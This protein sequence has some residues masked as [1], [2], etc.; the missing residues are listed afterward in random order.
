[1]AQGGV[2]GD[3]TAA[4]ACG[5]WI[6]FADETGQGLRPPKGRTWSRC[7]QTPVVVVSGRRSPRISIAG[8]VCVKP[9]WRPRLIYRLLA[10]RGRRGEQKGF[11][12]RD[13]LRL[14]TAAH[15]QLGGKIMIVWDNL[16]GHHATVIQEFVA[17]H[18]WLTV[19]WLPSYAPE[20]N[21]TEGI[22]SYLK[23]G[24]L[25]NLV[26]QGLDHLISVVKTALKRAQ[27]RPGLLW[28]VL[29]ETGLILEP[30]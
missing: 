1:V 26:A 9:G 4:A 12:A 18:D 24:V 13:F 11:R 16:P 25:A 30:S 5:A 29:A 17:E 27:Y 10:H 28:G 7:G 2:A 8:L 22:W 20:L 21:P 15:H 14:L 19:Y 6:C 3:K 23:G